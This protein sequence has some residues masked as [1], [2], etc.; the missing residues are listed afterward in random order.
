MAIAAVHGNCS[1]QLKHSKTLNLQYYSTAVAAPWPFAQYQR[2]RHP[3]KKKANSSQLRCTCEL[4]TFDTERKQCN[5]KKCH[6]QNDHK[7]TLGALQFGRWDGPA[8]SLRK[9]SEMLELSMCTLVGRSREAPVCSYAGSA[10]C[11]CG[12]GEYRD[13]AT[14]EESRPIDLRDAL[15]H[16][17]TVAVPL[18]L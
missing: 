7:R 3:W 12:L 9:L 15:M 10:D 5:A 4:L 8:H 18:D 6:A 17:G 13:D 14:H 1:L 2:H 16:H 11:H